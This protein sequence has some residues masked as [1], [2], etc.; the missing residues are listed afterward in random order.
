[1]H[2]MPT[3]AKDVIQICPQGQVEKVVMQIDM[4]ALEEA[5]ALRT[6][7]AMLGQMINSV[8][9]N[10]KST[11]DGRYNQFNK[12]IFLRDLGII[13]EFVNREFPPKSE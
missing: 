7:S 1:M 13:T 8:C 2:Q 10:L 9:E 6:L 5:H 3:D 12:N 11:N 4:A